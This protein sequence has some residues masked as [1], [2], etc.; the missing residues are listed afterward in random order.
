MQKFG[1]DWRMGMYRFENFC[2][3]LRIKEGLLEPSQTITGVAIDSRDVRPGNIFFALTGA[4]T[5]GH[6]YLAQVK[7]LGAS[8]AVVN[9]EF[10]GDDYGLPL[11]RVPNTLKALQMAA[12]G[13]V[14]SGSR[15]QVLAITGSLGKT[16]MKGFVT[17]L[18]RSTY[19]VST[20]SGNKNSQAGL[21]LALL[22]ETDGT[23]DYLVVEMGMTEPNQIKTLTE[24]VPPDIALITSIALVHAENFPSLQEI[25]RAKAE[26]FSHPKTQ[27]VIVNRDTACSDFLLGLCTCKKET[28][29]VKESLQVSP[30]GIAF[31]ERGDVFALPYVHF[32]ASHVY[33]NL[34]GAI[35]AAR[36]CHVSM[37][38]II[39]TL[40]SLRLPERR[41]QEVQKD[42]ILFINDAYNAAELSMKGALEA[43]RERVV[44]GR[45]IGVLGHMAELGQFSNEC[46]QRVGAFSIDC[47]DELFCFG[48]LCGPLYEEWK[49]A[50]KP[51]RWFLDF[52]ELMHELRKTALPGDCVL[53]KGARSLALERV[54]ETF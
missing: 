10:T 49:V 35:T 30:E 31:T 46:H 37:D 42:D 23:E 24:I 54:V 7:A 33:V 38:A 9:H 53:V 12:H 18:L 51:A 5:D 41:L 15:A 26:I 8:L 2:N 34:L 43:M 19:K 52:D 21:A 40:P 48:K 39:A 28:Y 29:S 45:K 25:A 13:F 1:L 20:T 6:R 32:P 4:K 17:Q 27:H 50:Q 44:A 3:W 22:N 47:V 16:T 11:I 36:A 14:S